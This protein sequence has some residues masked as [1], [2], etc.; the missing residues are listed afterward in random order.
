M[1]NNGTYKDEGVN[2][3]AGLSGSTVIVTGGAQGIG[4]AVAQSLAAEGARVAVADL[5]QPTQTVDAIVAAGGEALGAICDIADRSSVGEFVEHILGRFGRVDGL[6]TAAAMFSSLV[7]GPFEEISSEEFDRVMSVN[8][9]GTFEVVRAVAPS[10]RRQKSGSIVTIG[11]GTTFK[12][13]PGLLHYVSSKGAIIALTRSLAREL[14][15]DGV[16][17]N[18]V[19]PGL[20]ASDGVRNNA[21]NFPEAMMTAT[22]AS[23]CLPREQ[24][25]GDLTGVIA[26]LLGA[27]SEFMSGQSVVVDGGSVL[28]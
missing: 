15:A 9:R 7:P 20:T 21:G 3:V 2:G 10:M 28:N 27:G 24:T 16:R 19:V 5:Q 13:A 14:G 6:V 4:A 8:V 11:S 17:V 23:R 25:P 1:R 18:C 22:V 26:F 12:G